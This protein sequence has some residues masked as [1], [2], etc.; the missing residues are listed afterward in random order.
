MDKDNIEDWLLL[1]SSDFS[2]LEHIMSDDEADKL[3]FNKIF[4]AELERQ[5]AQYN[6]L[7]EFPIAEEEE[8]QKTVKGPEGIEEEAEEGEEEIDGRVEEV[9]R[10]KEV[11]TR[12]EVI[13][14]EV[15]D[16]AEVV[17]G[18]SSQRPTRFRTRVREGRQTAATT[19]YVEPR[20]R[21]RVRIRGIRCR[22]GRGRHVS[23]AAI[24]RKQQF[25]PSD[26]N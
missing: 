5:V 23:P 16:Q 3:V 11:T 8:A 14:E 17:R 7:E 1:P 13:C 10:E 22:G 2:D 9:I 26:A 20:Q 24:W 18:L 4:N 25:I 6:N 19:P 21:G 12:V 15:E